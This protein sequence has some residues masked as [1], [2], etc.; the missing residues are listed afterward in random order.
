MDGHLGPLNP[1][2]PGGL[3]PK[4]HSRTRRHQPP[5]HLVHSSSRM[6]KSYPLLFLF[7][8]MTTGSTRRLRA[9][10]CSRDRETRNSMTIP[11]GGSI[12]GVCA[13]FFSSVPLFDT[14]RRKRTGPSLFS[15]LGCEL[16]LTVLFLYFDVMY[17]CTVLINES[18][19]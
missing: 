10:R 14:C 7:N 6:F 15:G 2:V 18:S 8:D 5:L 1:H 4:R 17:L 12:R 11:N 16:T 9:S 13:S 3:L 19:T